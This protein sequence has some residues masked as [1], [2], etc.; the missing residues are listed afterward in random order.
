[1]PPPGHLST[2][3]GFE[4]NPGGSLAKAATDLLNS[5]D[6]DTCY[7]VG[8]LQ[9]ALKDWEAGK[10]HMGDGVES[11]GEP[12]PRYRLLEDGDK[13]LPTDYWLLEDTETWVSI[14]EVATSWIGAIFNGSFHH[15]C[16]RPLLD[17][18]ETAD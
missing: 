6:S 2:R 12:K 13:I 7:D 14:G 10:A 11:S 17:E 15:P 16:R 3:Q 9:E 4:L 5:M 8:P 1:M 18:A